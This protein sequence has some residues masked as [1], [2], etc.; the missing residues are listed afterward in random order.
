M[1]DNGVVRLGRRYIL[2]PTVRIKR[3]LPHSAHFDDNY[4]FSFNSE[5]KRKSSDAQPSKAVDTRRC[6]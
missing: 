2:L 1:A 6:Y 3:T 5:F 4:D